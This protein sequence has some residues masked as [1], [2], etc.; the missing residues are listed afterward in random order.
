MMLSI[1]QVSTLQQRVAA[2][3]LFREYL[4]WNKDE[5]FRH[6]GIEWD[7][8][9]TLE[10]DRETIEQFMRPTGRLL[11]A[12]VKGQ[13]VGVLSM[14]VHADGTAELKRMYVRPSWRRNGIGEALVARI[15]DEARRD[16]RH[17]IRLDSAG[18]MH[19]A[20]RM[21]RRL[22]FHDTEP[23]AESEI[24]EELREHWVFM[25]LSMETNGDDE[26]AR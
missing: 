25:A 15:I 6:Y 26:N 2:I 22:G 20:H 8:H 19:E 1:D 3:E 12:S 16:G 23:Y 14:K 7:L 13:P 10:H 18:Y 24:P 4:N 9:A 17:L 11:L 21:Y 5:L